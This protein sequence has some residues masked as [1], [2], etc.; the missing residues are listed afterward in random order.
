M[1]GNQLHCNY[2]HFVTCYKTQR[3]NDIETVDKFYLRLNQFFII[4]HDHEN[5]DSSRIV[6]RL[7]SNPIA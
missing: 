3:S 2:L 7:N 1:C 4:Y 6:Y 5:K